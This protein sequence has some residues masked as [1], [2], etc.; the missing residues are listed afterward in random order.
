M[1]VCGCLIWERR[2]RSF[3]VLPP[4]V[5]LLCNVG[6][7]SGHISGGCRAGASRVKT[8]RSVLVWLFR[9]STYGDVLLWFAAITIYGWFLFYKSPNLR[10][11]RCGGDQVLVQRNARGDGRNVE[12]Y[13]GKEEPSSNCIDKLDNS[14]A[15]PGRGGGGR[16]PAER[17]T[18]HA[19]YSHAQRCPSRDHHHHGLKVIVT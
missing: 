13:G 16:R 6:V 11:W 10:T 8:M 4:D 12:V 17:T 2:T 1:Q 18:H 19:R 5:H 3:L 9:V 7:I 14:E 15:T